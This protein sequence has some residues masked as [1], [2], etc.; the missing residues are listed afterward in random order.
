MLFCTQQFLVFFLL[1]FSVYWALPS[2][3]LRVWFLLAA[4]YYFYASWNPLLARLIFATTA[5]DYLL[6]RLM[7]SQTSPRL[8]HS[9]LLLSLLM[10]VGLLI[11]FKYA[12]FFLA[13]LTEALHA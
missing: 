8:R 3:R 4:S 2:Q 1:V 5:A 13:S 7:D 6:A 12:N 9:L 11:Y 10:N